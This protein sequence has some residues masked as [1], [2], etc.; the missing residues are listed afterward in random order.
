MNDYSN[1][2]LDIFKR[3]QT[4]NKIQSVDSVFACGS[5]TGSSLAVTLWFAEWLIR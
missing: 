4:N 2:V 3:S 5:R 1:V